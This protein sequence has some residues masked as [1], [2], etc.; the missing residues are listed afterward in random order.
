MAFCMCDSSDDGKVFDEMKFALNAI[1][2]T[3]IN[4][5]QVRSC[6]PGLLSVSHSRITERRIPA[7]YRKVPNRCRGFVCSS[8]RGARQ[9]Y[10]LA[11]CYRHLAAG[12]GAFR[13]QRLFGRRNSKDQVC[14]DGPLGYIPS[15]GAVT[16]L[17]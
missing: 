5:L 7:S 8:G 10:R 14:P 3:L 1:P 12:S 16:H 13:E 4:M 15:W 6:L 9:H 11:E 17:W 2:E